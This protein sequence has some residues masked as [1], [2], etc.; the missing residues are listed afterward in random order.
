MKM[1]LALAIKTLLA[2]ASFDLAS[3][4]SV[5]SRFFFVP[6]AP[7]SDRVPTSANLQI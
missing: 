7:S 6:P 2:Q 4:L 5:N 3:H 1:S